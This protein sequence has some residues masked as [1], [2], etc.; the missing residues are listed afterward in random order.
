MYIRGFLKGHFDKN[1]VRYWGVPWKT[2]STIQKS[3]NSWGVCQR[4][5]KFGKIVDSDYERSCCEYPD[6]LDYMLSFRVNTDLKMAF[7][8]HVF[9]TLNKSESFS[10][11]PE[12]VR[13]KLMAALKNN[14][15]EQ[16]EEEPWRRLK[17][18]CGMQCSDFPSSKRREWWS[19]WK[20]FVMT[21]KAWL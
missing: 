9:V 16:L 3:N 11:P 1:P 4:H 14:V 8:T 17:L 7:P 13:E 15:H 21:G 2:I 19:N 20:A 18:P 10:W 6:H 12:E 5:F